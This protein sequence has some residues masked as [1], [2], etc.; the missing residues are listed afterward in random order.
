M[1]FLYI[2]IMFLMAG[3]FGAATMVWYVVPEWW[4]NMLLLDV[5]GLGGFYIAT[6]KLLKVVRNARYRY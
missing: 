2:S 6:E 3:L 5:I 4:G 1:K